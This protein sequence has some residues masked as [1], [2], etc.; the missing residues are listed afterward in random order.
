MWKVIVTRKQMS[1]MD[2]DISLLEG[3]NHK[4]YMRILFVVHYSKKQQQQIY[5]GYYNVIKDLNMLQKSLLCM[6]RG[7]IVFMFFVSERFRMS[8]KS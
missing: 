6:C 2:S 5:T 4:V 7:N 1:K 8:R 3:H